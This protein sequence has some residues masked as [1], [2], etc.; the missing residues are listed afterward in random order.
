MALLVLG[1]MVSGC[2]APDSSV[3]FEG[4][5]TAAGGNWN[6]CSSRCML[7][8]AGNPDVACAEVCEPL[9][10]CGGIAGFSCP[11]GYECKTPQGVADALGYCVPSQEDNSCTLSGGTVETAMCCMSS[12]DFPN[13]CAIGACGCSPENSHEVK[14]CSCGEGMCFDGESCVALVTSF[15]GCVKEGYPV[16]ESYPRQCRGPD[17]TIYNEGEEMC[18][19]GNGTAMSLL[20]AI[21]IALNSTCTE[22]GTLREGYQCNDFTGTWWLDLDIQKEGCSPACV[23]DIETGTAEI[24][25]RCTGLISPE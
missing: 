15:S 8:N 16:M 20:D 2:T 14:V 21:E 17:G 18:V 13:T 6:E 1:V 24:N 5:C 9:C 19:T 12:G 22:N 25:W 23:V 3:G 11:G 10:E 7:D 4:Q